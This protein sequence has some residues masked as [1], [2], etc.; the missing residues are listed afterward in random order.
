MAANNGS[1]RTALCC[2]CFLLF[3]CCVFLRLEDKVGSKGWK[4]QKKSMDVISQCGM[5]EPLS[6]ITVVQKL[7]KSISTVFG[8][9]ENVFLE[10]LPSTILKAR[11]KDHYLYYLY[12]LR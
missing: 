3:T 10:A 9:S 1:V 11:H 2:C 8:I 7:E 5:C 12:C 6:A 4:L